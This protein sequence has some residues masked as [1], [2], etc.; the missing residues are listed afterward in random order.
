MRF[1]HSFIKLSSEFGKFTI[2][3]EILTVDRFESSELIEFGTKKI[4][5]TI[6]NLSDFKVFHQNN[7]F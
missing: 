5:E 7:V 1:H 4:E 3:S 6:R 2:S